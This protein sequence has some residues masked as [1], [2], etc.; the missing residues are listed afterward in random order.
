MKKHSTYFDFSK[1]KEDHQSKQSLTFYP[2]PSKNLDLG[3]VNKNSL[4]TK[5][6]KHGKFWVYTSLSNPLFY[7]GH[8][9]CASISQVCRDSR[10]DTNRFGHRLKVRSG[11]IYSW[12]YLIYQGLIL[13]LCNMKKKK[14]CYFLPDLEVRLCS[15]IFRKEKLRGYQATHT[16]LHVLNI[17]GEKSKTKLTM[18]AKVKVRGIYNNYRFLPSTSKEKV[19]L[20]LK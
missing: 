3:W 15:S 7:F 16:N 11:K 19:A 6:L 4:D 1:T 20:S 10:R 18:F 14:R 12:N 2:L 9:S 13:Y 17:K 8:S 5:F